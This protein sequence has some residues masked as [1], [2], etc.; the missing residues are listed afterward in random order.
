LMQAYVYACTRM[1]V[2]ALARVPRI[3]ARWCIHIDKC[4]LHAYTSTIYTHAQRT[5][6]WALARVIDASWCI[7][8]HKVLL[9]EV[10]DA[11]WCIYIYASWEWLMQ[12]N[13]QEFCVVKT[14][15]CCLC[16]T[17][18]C[19]KNTFLVCMFHRATMGKE[20]V[21]YSVNISQSLP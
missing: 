7:C 20:V 17:G 13:S 4:N 3:D 19:C 12:V 5:A 15:V 16:S 14:C 1:A 8:I 18:L 9:F 10:I 21:Y 2:S 11:S 6:V